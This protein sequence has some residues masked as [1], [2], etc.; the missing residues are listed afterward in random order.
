MKKLFLAITAA[1][2]F[3]A[4]NNTPAVSESATKVNG[5]KTW[6]DS[7]SAE[8]T[9]TTTFDS[10]NW[11]NLSAQYQEKIAGINESELDET[12]KTLLGTL[13]ASWTATEDTYKAGIM[14]AKEEAA[15]VVAPIDSTAAA[16]P[17]D[18]STLIEKV[19][20]KGAEKTKEALKK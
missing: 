15:K 18:K 9:K 3:A 4:C 6:V 14:K 12:T 20:D 17:A 7:I 19:I 1:A 8:V 11:A 13:K 16:A 10:A 2:F 5:L